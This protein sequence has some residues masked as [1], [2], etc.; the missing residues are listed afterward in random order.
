MIPQ[1]PSIEQDK[2]ALGDLLGFL[3]DWGGEDARADGGTGINSNIVGIPDS[4]S[5]G[6]PDAG[7]SVGLPRPG[8]SIGL[9]EPG[10][11]VGLPDDLPSFDDLEMD[12]EIGIPEPAKPAPAAAAPVSDF[13]VYSDEIPPVPLEDYTPMDVDD[14]PAPTSAA[15]VAAKPSPYVY[16]SVDEGSLEELP[17]LDELPSFDEL[18]APDFGA[19][20]SGTEYDTEFILGE[21]SETLDS[22]LE[23]LG[24]EE[25][26]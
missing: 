18:G 21:E 25:E 15:P 7:G 4:I 6:I 8:G 12:L 26:D 17:P 23:D 20:S 19:I 13:K 24:W 5:I 9:P 16:E 11:S 2:E 10:G 3:D 1:L 14:E 22:V